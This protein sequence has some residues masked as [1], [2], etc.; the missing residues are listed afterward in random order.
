MKQ[1]AGHLPTGI[2]SSLR[3]IKLF[4]NTVVTVGPT[5]FATDL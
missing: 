4:Y 1:H 3:P 5:A 2:M